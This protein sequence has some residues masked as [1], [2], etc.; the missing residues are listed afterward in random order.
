MDWISHFDNSDWEGSIGTTWVAD[1]WEAR[2][3]IETT[4]WLTSIGT[5]TVGFRPTKVRVTFTTEKGLPPQLGLYIESDGH[6][7]PSLVYEND[8]V[9]M[10]EADITWDG[11]D[12]S[13]IGFFFENLDEDVSVT[14]I[15]FYGTE[16]SS[17]SSS[18]SSSS[19]SSESSSSSSESSSSSLLVEVDCTAA[20]S[21]R[22]ED[23]FTD[24]EQY[25]LQQ[26]FGYDYNDEDDFEVLKMK[27]WVLDGDVP[28]QCE[29]EDYDINNPKNHFKWLLNELTFLD[30][31]VRTFEH[32]LDYEQNETDF[33][34]LKQGRV[35]GLDDW[36]NTTNP[37][38]GRLN[39]D[40]ELPYDQR[41]TLL[42]DSQ[43]ENLHDAFKVKRTAGELSGVTDIIYKVT[44]YCI[45]LEI[46]DAAN[47]I[48]SP[49]S[50]EI[51]EGVIEQAGTE[52]DKNDRN[53]VENMNEIY[54]E[55][56]DIIQTLLS[57]CTSMS[58]PAWQ[59]SHSYSVG[60]KVTYGGTIYNCIE[61][62][63]SSSESF[64]VDIDK[65]EVVSPSTKIANLPH[66][67]LQV[68]LTKDHSS[69]KGIIAAGEGYRFAYKDVNGVDSDI[70]D[71]PTI[72]VSASNI[73]TGEV[74]WGF[75]DVKYVL[76]Y[77]TS[78]PGGPTTWVEDFSPVV[79]RSL[80]PSG[81][82]TID[83]T[84]VERFDI[85]NERWKTINDLR[86]NKI[87]NIGTRVAIESMTNTVVPFLGDDRMNHFDDKVNHK[88][89]Y[90]AVLQ[91]ICPE[92]I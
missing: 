28:E 35:S 9:S 66:K 10:A 63:T 49:G 34:D 31:Y 50:V 70:P 88:K 27:I 47:Q 22:T 75:E 55:I 5:W 62:H 2:I 36:I 11:D 33:F 73:K 90:T 44:D 29:L 19:S 32:T 65:W 48:M 59:Y 92:F 67:R 37:D 12:I 15:E 68:V 81:C 64:D 72:T 30:I 56:F 51:K 89:N 21:T 74:E 45:D 84:S 41:P 18:E 8:Y 42:T 40:Y 25:I 23:N 38:T 82:S 6:G 52:Q 16:E 13:A 86:E 17:S 77:V 83:C 46:V 61:A 54:D 78:Q 26:L 80:L 57:S 91:E 69:H 71:N 85:L 4:F 7:A 24:P 87:Q 1:H 60:N 53:Y 58:A 14:N 39:K 76:V 20:L 43:F 79:N 3:T